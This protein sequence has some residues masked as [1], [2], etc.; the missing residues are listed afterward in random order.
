M[1]KK[2]D[3]A[4]D[5]NTLNG[6]NWFWKRAI[7]PAKLSEILRWWNFIYIDK[8]NSNTNFWYLSVCHLSICLEV[9]LFHGSHTLQLTDWKQERLNT[10]TSQQ[11]TWTPIL[12]FIEIYM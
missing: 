9:R 3:D 2:F 11:N 10:P 8:A 5:K 4:L 12:N 7:T 6:L 1:P